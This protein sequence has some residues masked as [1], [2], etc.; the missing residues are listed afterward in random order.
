MYYQGAKLLLYLGDD[1]HAQP[2]TATTIEVLPLHLNKSV[3]LKVTF[4]ANI[5]GPTRV[6]TSSSSEVVT[7]APS[8]SKGDV[9][10]VKFYDRRFAHSIREYYKLPRTTTL[11]LT[12]EEGEEKSFQKYQILCNHKPGMSLSERE[13]ALGNSLGETVAPTTTT[14]N[15]FI[16]KVHKAC[17]KQCL[18]ERDVYNRSELVQGTDIPILY[19]LV[20]LPGNDSG[21]AHLPVSIPGHVIGNSEDPSFSAMCNKVNFEV[22]EAIQIGAIPL[23]RD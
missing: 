19:S 14:S 15:L 5:S 7:P 9:A 23:L 8:L 20:W 17:L 2:I 18:R 16:E 10:V 1:D 6:S 13:K 22:S 4:D 21:I 3:V 11:D 12:D